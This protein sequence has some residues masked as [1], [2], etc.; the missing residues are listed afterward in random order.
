MSQN[1]NLPARPRREAQQGM[2]SRMNF[3]EVQPAYAELPV[4]RP[5]SK[6]AARRY[7]GPISRASVLD[8]A[9]L[10]SAEAYIALK[11]RSPESVQG[12]DK[13]S[14]WSAGIVL[15]GAA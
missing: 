5:G 15:S 6:S 1:R 2:L 8:T 9:A 10:R 7:K 3:K 13:T 4:I 12:G 14:H 11:S